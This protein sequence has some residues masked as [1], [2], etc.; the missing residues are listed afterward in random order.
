MAVLRLVLLITLVVTLFAFPSTALACTPPPGGLPQY[1]VAERVNAAPIVIE[2]AVTKIDGQ[3]SPYT[4]TINVIRY[5]KGSG[6]DTI[7]VK[8]YGSSSLCLSDVRV[9]DHRIFYITGNPTSGYFAFYM[10]QFDAVAPATGEVTTQII[11]AVQGR[12][13]SPTP[14]FTPNP[15]LTQQSVLTAT[16][17][18][19]QFTASVLT[20]TAR[21]PTLQAQFTNSALTTTALAP[22]NNF[23]RTQTAG[24]ATARI[25]TVRALTTTSTPQPTAT[26]TPTP[27]PTPFLGL[28]PEE[29]SG[30]F[31]SMGCLVGGSLGLLLMVGAVGVTIFVMRR[32]PS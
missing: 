29:A 2:G 23:I 14:S 13:I 3:T 10:S 1:T 18:Q 21:A 15:T 20:S 5:F 16:A 28:S 26:I 6:T 4:A 19:A 17:R 32:K 22:T 9:N 24:S 31:L 11:A 30:A 8:N 7:Q 12:P 27:T 25:A